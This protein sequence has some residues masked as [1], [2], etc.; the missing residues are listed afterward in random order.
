MASPLGD[1]G[2]SGSHPPLHQ[3][4]PDDY[5]SWGDNRSRHD[6]SATSGR[7]SDGQGS[8][9]MDT[10]ANSSERK[11]LF[12]SPCPSNASGN[13]SESSP[14]VI[15]RKDIPSY[16]NDDDDDDDGDDEEPMLSILNV[17]VDHVMVPPTPMEPEEFDIFCRQRRE[18]LKKQEEER[19]RKLNEEESKVDSSAV[20]EAGGH[21]DGDDEPML[22]PLSQQ[23]VRSDPST[24]GFS[25]ALASAEQSQSFLEQTPTL[26]K[27]KV[28]VPVLRF[29]GPV[30]RGDPATVRTTPR[31]S[32]CLHVHGAFPY[33]VARPVAA[34]PDGSSY[35]RPGDS[36]RASVSSRIDWDDAESVSYIVDEI[37]VKL[38]AALRATDEWKEKRDTMD[39]G[40]AHISTNNAGGNN[41]DGLGGT[42][43]LDSSK[44]PIR[45]IRQVTVVKGKGFYTYCCGPPAP[46]LRVE[47]YDPKSKWK[48]K[49]MLERGLDVD[50][51]YHPDGRFYDYGGDDSE[52][53][54]KHDVSHNDEDGE[55]EVRGERGMRQSSPPLKFRC[56]EAHIPYT[57]QVFKDLNLS[58]MSYI[59]VKR[60]MFRQSLPKKERKRVQSSNADE[61]GNERLFLDD[62]VSDRFQWGEPSVTD[63][64]ATPSDPIA[65]AEGLGGGDDTKYCP[66]SFVGLRRDDQF[67]AAKESL[68]DVEL[69]ASSTELL[70]IRDV[71]TSLPDDPVERARVHWRAV[72]SLREIWELER[73]RMASL[74]SEEDDFLNSKPDDEEDVPSLQLAANDGRS[75]PGARL[76]LRGSK[77]LYDPSPG[78]EDDYRRA[79][80]DIA[81][82]HSNFLQRVDN[83]LKGDGP[84][85]FS[86]KIQAQTDSLGLSTPS[87][88]QDEALAA[89]NALGEQ[90]GGDFE[91]INLRSQQVAQASQLSSLSPQTPSSRLNGDSFRSSPLSQVAPLT[92]ADIED[93]QEATA[94]GHSL[95]RGDSVL[96]DLTPKSSSVDPFSLLTLHEN[97]YDSDEDVFH[98]EEKLGEEGFARSLSMLATQQPSV[99][100]D[101]HN[102]EKGDGEDIEKWDIGSSQMRDQE[103]E[104]GAGNF[105]LSQADRAI[106]T[107]REEDGCS[108]SSDEEDRRFHA[109]NEDDIGDDHSDVS[110]VDNGC[111]L[112]QDSQ[113]KCNAEM[114]SESEKQ[115]EVNLSIPQCTSLRRGEYVLP[116]DSSL[117]PRRRDCN[118]KKA[119]GWHAVHKTRGRP[120]PWLR[121]SSAYEMD[122]REE[123]V[124]LST[125]FCSNDKAN[126]F[127]E[128]VRR[129]P[130]SH[131]VRAW[132]KKTERKEKDSLRKSITKDTAKKRKRADLVIDD[133]TRNLVPASA[134]N[135]TQKKR[136]VAFAN[137]V[138]HQ[139]SCQVFQVEEIQVESTSNSQMSQSPYQSQSSLLSLSQQ[140]EEENQEDDHQ[141]S[142]SQKDGAKKFQSLLASVGSQG[143]ADSL[144]QTEG[145]SSA[146][147][148]SAFDPSCTMG[149]GEGVSPL[150]AADALEGIGQQGGKIHVAGGGG[151]KGE[152]GIASTNNLPSAP[153]PLTI[154]SIEVH[155]QCRTGKAGA[156]D[157]KTIAM[158]PDPSRDKVAACV[159][160]YARDPGGGEAIEILERGVLFTP[161]EAEI[162]GNA[163][164]DINRFVRK[165]LGISIDRAKVEMLR[166]ERQLLLRLASIVKYKDPDALMSWDT[167]GGGLGYLIERG[168]AIAKGPA[169]SNNGDSIENNA[170]KRGKEIDMVKLL[171]RIIKKTTTSSSSS[172]VPHD[173]QQE[174]GENSNEWS[175]S[176]LGS[177]W[178]ERVGAG[179]AA[180][181]IVSVCTVYFR[182]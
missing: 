67:W 1:D 119:K 103:F 97:E 16:D 12:H 37:H 127:V 63:I 11:R 130:S 156:H 114:S 23:S 15:Q 58:G 177:D 46:F 155:V 33:L 3:T 95:E 62:N 181:S 90:F 117:V 135:T 99:A 105:L 178:D 106:E 65:I 83:A 131:Q 70:N 36:S 4:L 54:A 22:F 143:S 108:L 44:L 172:L 96:G 112:Y 77:R 8:S 152:A 57:M 110:A 39:G 101:E 84:A 51:A 40:G 134:P 151:L 24:P 48:V 159:Y 7:K 82:R 73:R 148:Y 85:V 94:F 80:G 140:D 121:L 180:A 75:L 71:M 20:D 9:S 102:R 182:L 43:T 100:S 81:K 42:S 125:L 13:A 104:E 34:G 166:S 144:H 64:N 137:D 150:S 118:A 10:P 66:Y 98:E 116:R 27:E 60:G 91:Q 161:V 164:E 47:Y 41:G 107:I 31:Q 176:G 38:E 169:T 149:H 92:Q 126:V 174:G 157:S 128:P 142:S 167:Q 74:L 154:I 61:S 25:G 52:N 93:I 89:L 30:I 29:F 87:S 2:D 50:E 18:E 35:R 158:R 72:P 115:H 53:A 109:S 160:L 32:G 138:A 6:G 86:P 76:A 162:V 28:L 163:S 111:T 45:Y 5:G 88:S 136:R 139:S 122:S 170:P 173:Q 171:G 133:N 168:V 56:Y 69:D 55:D 68:C 79:L 78:L 124:T 147:A 19:L 129:P 14:V 175:G 21:H 120:Q 113:E 17:V 146:R 132:L 123:E 179:A 141:V 153:T 49:L 59:K 165:S 26:P 145:L